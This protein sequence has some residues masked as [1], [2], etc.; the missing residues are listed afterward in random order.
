MN[1]VIKYGRL[2]RKNQEKALQ[3]QKEEL[4]QFAKERDYEIAETGILTRKTEE[5]EKLHGMFIDEGTY[6]KEIIDNK[7]SFI[8]MLDEAKYG[9]FNQILIE[10]TSI[11]VK[12]GVFNIDNRILGFNPMELIEDLR[13][14]KVNVHF[15]KE[16][17]DTIDNSNNMI[18]SILF[19]TAEFEI[20]E[21]IKRH[22]RNQ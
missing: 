22:K 19:H 9:E 21:G 6:K 14:N 11:F 3:K 2:P 8:T 12:C 17:L 16:N 15:M 13:V 20:I 5:T 1:K 18:L 4:M 10:D 7:N